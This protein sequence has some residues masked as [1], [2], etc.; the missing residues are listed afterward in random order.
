MIMAAP[1]GACLFV[2]S[3]PQNVKLLSPLYTVCDPFLNFF[4]GMLA[5]SHTS[6]QHCGVR[7][8]RWALQLLFAR[9]AFLA[10]ALL[11]RGP[12]RYMAGLYSV[13]FRLRWCG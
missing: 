3:V 7:V 6:R 9:R 10:G 12:T 8:V 2:P 4:R 1:M 5:Y 13:T 11:G